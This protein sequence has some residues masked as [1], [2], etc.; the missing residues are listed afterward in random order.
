[1]LRDMIRN[2]TSIRRNRKYNTSIVIVVYD[3]TLP[4]LITKLTDRSLNEIDMMKKTHPS[5]DVPPAAS[6]YLE[7]C[8][9]GIRPDP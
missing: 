5:I 4:Q 1:M 6:T 2:I 9:T 3:H 7:A 8:W